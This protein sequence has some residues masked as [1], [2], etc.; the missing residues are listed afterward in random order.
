MLIM[1]YIAE[2]IHDFDKCDFAVYGS[3]KVGAL[4]GEHLFHAVHQI[5]TTGDLSA[6]GTGPSPGEV[7]ELARTLR[8]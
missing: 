2:H 1:D 7:M 3:E 8:Q 5:F 4:V 6:F